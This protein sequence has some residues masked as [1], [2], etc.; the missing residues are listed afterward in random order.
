LVFVGVFQAISE[1][2]PVDR[3]AFGHKPFWF[4]WPLPKKG[5]FRAGGSSGQEIR[6]SEHVLAPT[7]FRKHV[8]VCRTDHI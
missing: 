7:D 4:R 3:R 1:Q 2:I 8:G 6:P 5:Q